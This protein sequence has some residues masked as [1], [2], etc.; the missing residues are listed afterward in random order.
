M[1]L[2][3]LGIAMAPPSRHYQTLTVSRDKITAAAAGWLAVDE[4]WKLA[5]TWKNIGDWFEGAAEG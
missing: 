1:A 5:F 3:S 4:S 2:I